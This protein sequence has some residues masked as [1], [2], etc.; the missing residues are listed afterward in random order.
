MN[1]D[2]RLTPKTVG[3]TA[4]PMAT[5]PA[6]TVTE[7]CTHSNTARMLRF[8]TTHHPMAG[9]PFKYPLEHEAPPMPGKRIS[10][11]VRQAEKAYDPPSLERRTQAFW[12]RTKAYERTRKLR[13][14]GKKFYFID[15][16]PYT[17]GHIHL[18]TAWNKILKDAQ[19]RWLRMRGL[20]VR[21]QAGYDMHGLPIEV[22]VEKELG[23]KNKK[24]IE[25]LGIARFIKKCREFSM[26]YLRVMTRE[27]QELGVWLDWERPYRTIDNTFIEGA[28]W[29]LSKAQERGLLYQAEKGGMSWCPR[30][31]TALA[32]AEVEYEEVEDPAVYVKFPVEGQAGT[33]LVIWTTTP[34]TLPANCAVAAHPDF[35]YA[36]VL[37]RK[38]GKEET[39]I[40]LDERVDEVVALGRYD[41]HVVVGHATGKELEGT[42]YA[43][44]FAELPYHRSRPT[45]RNSTVILG[46][47]VSAENTGLVHTATGHGQED[48]EV[49]QRYGIPPFCPVD[50][51]GLF[52]ADAGT[53]AGLYVKDADPRLIEDLRAKGLLL[54]DGKIRHRYGLCWRCKT[55]ILYRTTRQWF[56]AITRVK[57][58][59]LEEVDR[60]SWTP[61]WA[62]S[63]RQRDWV[64]NA[65]DWCI[66]RQ[67][68][69]GIPI[70]VWMCDRGHEAVIGTVKALAARAVRGYRK[71]M[72]LHRPHIDRVVVRCDQ[73]RSDMRRIPDVFDVW[74]DSAC[75]SWAELRYPSTDKE[76]K[77][78]F[79]CDWIVE[80]Q[81]QTRGWFYS[82]LGAGV[83]ALDRCPYDRVL[84]HGWALDPEGKP[85]SKSLGNIVA[86]HD[87][88]A[89]HG[90]DAMRLYFMAGA[91]WEDVAFSWE[92]VRNCQRTLNVL[93]N[94]HYFASTYMALD[95]F[96][97]VPITGR[98][99]RALRPEDRW[100][101]SRLQSVVS[102]VTR[103]FERNEYHLG[104]R[105]IQSFVL[106]DLSRWYVRLARERTWLEEESDDKRACYA[107]LHECLVTLARLLAPYTPHVADALYQD[108]A[109][110]K[111]TVHMEDWPRYETRLRDERLESGMA[112][113]RTIVEA[114]LQARSKANLPLRWPVHAVYVAGEKDLGQVVASSAALLAQLTNAK[115][116][117]YV[118][119][120]WRN[121]LVAAAPVKNVIGKTF[122]ERAPAV[123]E[124]LKGL[125]PQDAEDL[126]RKLASD[127]SAP[128]LLGDTSRVTLTPEM[129]TFQTRLSPEYTGADIAGGAV[130]V[131]TQVTAAL[132]A[133]GLAREISRRIQQMRKEA[134]LRVDARIRTEVSVEPWLEVLVASAPDAVRE[135]IR[136]ATRSVALSFTPKPRGKHAKT[137]E[138]DGERVTIAITPAGRRY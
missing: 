45:P 96:R 1:K 27:F 70:P 7:Q 58:R 44:P 103:S 84:M 112:K 119:E 60:V 71:G 32:E 120:R 31:E 133:E 77:A 5:A 40:L 51:A 109:P 55:P 28:W 138:I 22:K 116:V 110:G 43:H 59:M 25:E 36:R 118:G 42:R 132:K 104:A 13:S 15:G 89:K 30:C 83:A 67:R 135:E 111:A 87:V 107:T 78:W 66:S 17:S 136:T 54:H 130:Y 79:P 2:P 108:L 74:F 126:R 50:E 94:V 73:C 131:D 106:E 49:G 18:G 29:A 72:D 14:K 123:V 69:W 9:I 62:G 125:N 137:W 114:C 12:K 98:L 56:L 85:M 95:E 80:A 113:A 33:Y 34:W 68:Y 64:Q 53:Y 23:I 37:A 90:A 26:G 117:E 52:T 21:D 105:A 39:L 86:P 128:L 134:D 19:L 88:V 46:E 41:E 10:G 20:H 47:H 8:A 97:P 57:D 61:E 76:F 91:P 81:D 122:R 6:S 48:F 99:A 115:R 100:L 93:W 11:A 38:G 92:G 63:A 16:P 3:S 4:A 102:E 124:R 82:Q 35:N 121:L 127:E 101:R 24:Q 65:R 75:A 129:V